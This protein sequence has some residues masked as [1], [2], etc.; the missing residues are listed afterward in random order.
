MTPDVILS[1]G[2]D[3]HRQ[4][5]ITS[6]YLEQALAPFSIQTVGKDALQREF[7][8]STPPKYFLAQTRHYSWPKGGGK[9]SYGTP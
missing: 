9:G 4:F 1:I 5:G 3:L 8:I 7:Q 6:K 2:D